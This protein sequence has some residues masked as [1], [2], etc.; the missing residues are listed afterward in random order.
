MG[1]TCTHFRAQRAR[2]CPLERLDDA[3]AHSPVL[4]DAATVTG[5]RHTLDEISGNRSA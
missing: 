1:A 3:P 5:A 2:R 4:A